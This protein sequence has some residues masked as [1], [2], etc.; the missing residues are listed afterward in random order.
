MPTTATQHGLRRLIARPLVT[1][2]HLG[3][4]VLIG[5]AACTQP[6][7]RTE[8]GPPLEPPLVTDAKPR[9]YPGLHQVVAYTPDIWS[10]GVPEGPDGFASLARLGILTVIS[11]DGAATDVEEA[12]RH[13]LRYVHLP[14]GYDGID[15]F[16]RLEIAR[17][18][19]DLPRPVYVHC[20][21]GKHR[22]AAAVGSTC[23]A[24]GYLSH[25]EAEARMHVSGIAAQYKG[26]FQA[27]R[28]SQPVDAATLK[29]ADASFPAQSQVS[30]MVEAMVAIDFAFE[31]VQ[32]IEKAGWK[33]PTDHPD[34][35][36]A[37]ELGRMADHFRTGADTL[38]KG[39]QQELIDWMKRSYTQVAELEAAF[40]AGAESGDQLSA[41]F[42]AISQNCKDCHAK[43]R[44]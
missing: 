1:L 13:G 29:T 16:R 21:H 18:V 5:L 19:H 11:V 28:D 42:K 14:H 40:V 3:A 7:L 17:A 32:H 22:S 2:R 38:P 8:V 10:G 35:V 33:V 26:L 34:L 23:V 39:E 36:P 20:H 37:A 24:L 30:D 25:A 31:N 9:E 12:S 43:Y 27:V 44:N 6:N 41:R 15:A 4:L